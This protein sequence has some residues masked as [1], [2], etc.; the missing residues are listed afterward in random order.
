MVLG[1]AE[2]QGGP[3][4]SLRGLHFAIAWRRLGDERLKEVMRCMSNLLNRS[5]KSIFVDFSRPGK[6]TQLPDK[7][8]RGSAHFLFRRRRREVMQSFDVSTH[9]FCSLG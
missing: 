3:G 8:Q 4:T 9:I 6:P 5:I 1:R 2:T 7:L